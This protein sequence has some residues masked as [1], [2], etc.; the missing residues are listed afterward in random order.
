MPR[1]GLSKIFRIPSFS[2]TQGKPDLFFL[3]AFFCLAGFGLLMLSSASVVVSY[4]KYNSSSYY[5]IH[6]LLFG[7]LPGS[8]ICFFCSKID[9]H[10]WKRFAFLFLIISIFLL[11]MVFMPGIGYE[12]GGARRWLHIGSLLFQPSEVVKLTFLIYLAAWLGNR[13]EK[14]VGDF[15]YGFVPFIAVV[16]TIS[17]LVI[18][19]PDMGTMGVIAL[20]ALCMYFVAGA[21]LAHI[22]LIAGG[23]IL[24]LFALIKAAPYRLERFM[25]FLHPELDPL[26][27]GYH[28]NQ[29]LLAVGSGGF[30]GRGFGH[31]RQKFAYLPE[32]TGDSIFAIAAEELGFVFSVLFISLFIFFAIRGLRIAMR[33]PDTFG[34]LVAVGIVSWIT[35]Q[36]F[37]NIGA[38][39]SILPLTG[40]PLPFVSYGGSSIVVL[41]AAVGILINISRHAK[42]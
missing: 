10:V 28:I 39:L 37:I 5:I 34:M 13:G 19:Q 12:Y 32:V 14:K 6:Q 8:I 22:G 20:I 42:T 7:V 41:L 31:S 18:T 33:A 35:F 3:I 11:I 26:G 16:G 9:Y 40:I 21:S 4:Q 25:T 29:A 2:G 15:S 23:S 1:K 38:M 27:V 36:A 30:W 17:L 24:A